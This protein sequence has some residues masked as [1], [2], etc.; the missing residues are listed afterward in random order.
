MPKLI[1]VVGAT[2]GQGGS[3]VSA[4]LKD[5]NFKIRGITRNPDG[6]VAKGLTARGVEMVRAD[7]NDKASLVKAF[8]GAYAIFAVTD[9]SEPFIKTDAEEAAEVEYQQGVNMAVAASKTAGLQHYLWS[10]LPYSHKLSQGKLTVPHFDGKARVDEFIKKDA[11][12]LSKTT[13]LYYTFYASNL[14]IPNFNPIFI[15]GAGKYVLLNPGNPEKTPIAS[16]GD[17]RTNVGI[18]AYSV[19]ANPPK[20]G[21][22]YV[23]CSAEDFPTMNA[24]FAQWGSGS[25]LVASSQST[26]VLQISIEQYKALWPKWGDEMG[27]MMI[28]WEL[29]GNNSWDPPPG[30]KMMNAYELM[31]ESA[32]KELVTTEEAFKSLDWAPLF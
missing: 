3:V 9:F 27:I 24:Y 15:K 7:L 11:Q 31:T 23:K 4:F 14:F 8:E 20:V 6:E 29:L 2:G 25:G 12:L 22:T 13:F 5:K 10:T 30:D 18:F 26:S 28:Y 16:L 19:L 21:G 1:V 32:K 17:H